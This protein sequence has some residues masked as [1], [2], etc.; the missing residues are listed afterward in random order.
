MTQLDDNNEKY[1]SVN[2]FEYAARALCPPTQ[3]MCKVTAL[4]SFILV[5]GFILVSQKQGIISSV[6]I[7]FFIT[8]FFFMLAFCSSRHN[9]LK[10]QEGK[11][12]KKKTE[13]KSLLNVNFEV[14]N[15]KFNGQSTQEE[16]SINFLLFFF[17][18]A[19]G[20]CT[21]KLFRFNCL[22]NSIQWEI[23]RMR[24]LN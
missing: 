17:F 8:V 12:H 22:N 21:L 16:I 2:E 24:A 20:Y 9:E 13:L 4:T 10:E 7:E 11:T 1:E 23:A 14:W 3:P 19:F 6:L 5:N 18:C 15:G